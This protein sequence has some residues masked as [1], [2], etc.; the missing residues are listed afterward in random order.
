MS[1]SR[2][3]WPAAKPSKNISA[4]PINDN[5]IKQV[6]TAHA[7]RRRPA[8]NL[9]SRRLATRYARHRGKTRSR[10]PLQL[11]TT[12]S[13]QFAAARPAVFQGQQNRHARLRGAPALSGSGSDAGFRR[14]AKIVEFI[15][16]NPKCTRRKLIEALAPLPTPAAAP[17]APAANGDQP[18][19]PAAPVANPEPTPEQ[20]VL[21]ADLHWL[22]HQ[23]H[24]IEF[25]NGIV[26][27]AKKPVVKPPK[28]EKA[29]PAPATAEAPAAE[30]A[31]QANA[32]TNA[33]PVEIPTESLAVAT[34]EA[35]PEHSAPAE[36]AA[37]PAV[38][39]PES[40]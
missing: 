7:E 30:A 13:Q 24:V 5:I 11:A 29:A 10:F 4:K 21:M 27:T 25:A 22:I 20:A 9:R 19:Q 40:Q 1:P 36:P 23:G 26:E 6:E 8:A 31:P 37:E 33:A 14:R 34:T 38:T 15:N 32:E 39:A 28:P 18:A 16:A 3:A 17:E 35:A 12:L 2:S